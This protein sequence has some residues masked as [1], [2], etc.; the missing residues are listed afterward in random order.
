MDLGLSDHHAQIL[1]V[2]IPD[3]SNIPHRIRKRQFSEANVQE[4]LYLL[5]QVTWQEVYEESDINAKFSTFMDVF[6]HCYNNAFPIKTVFVSDT[7][8]NNWITQGIKISSK[9]MQLLDNQRKTTVMKKKD[10]EYIEHYRKIY[11]RVI[12]EAEKE[13]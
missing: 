1:S 10:L 11:R 2:S 6:L 12:K 13:K 9:K 4:L 8:K 7:I 5:N 3:F